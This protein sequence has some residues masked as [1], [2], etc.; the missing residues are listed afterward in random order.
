MRIVLRRREVKIL[1]LVIVC[2]CALLVGWVVFVTFVFPVPKPFDSWSPYAEE[3]YYL[4]QP[5]ISSGLYEYVKETAEEIAMQTD[6]IVN[7]VDAR[8][9]I[10]EAWVEVRQPMLP[11]SFIDIAV[12]NGLTL[13]FTV[14]P[15]SPVDT[16]EKAYQ[17]LLITEYF[18]DVRDRVVE[19][20][21]LDT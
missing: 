3:Y 6:Q 16:M 12:A 13:N 2:T 8:E 7:V 9:G 14:E 21:T 17:R 11:Q 15:G 1:A 5:A 10:C 19:L 20:L 18:C 4:V